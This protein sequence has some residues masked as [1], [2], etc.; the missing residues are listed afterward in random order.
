MSLYES[1]NLPTPHFA[2]EGGNP[3]LW[4]K[5]G[6]R[7]FIINVGIISRLLISLA[8]FFMVGAVCAE[9]STY[10]PLD[11]YAYEA[12]ARLEA[13]GVIESGLTSM[14]PLSRK[15]MARL[16]VEAGKNAEGKSGSVRAMAGYLKERFADEING[17]RFV[18][19]V[20]SLSVRYAYNSSD[21]QALVYNNDGD[22]YREGS[23]EKADF[24]SRAE[25]GWISFY[26]NPEVGYPDNDL[27][28]L[29]A[30]AKAVDSALVCGSDCN[31]IWASGKKAEFSLKSAYGVASFL[32]LDLTLGKD[33][34]W[35]GPGYHG[36]FLLSNNAE[37][38]TMVRIENPE[39]VLLP[40]IFRYLGP[41]RVAFF[42]TQ[43]EDDRN[44]VPEPYYWGMRLDFKPHPRVEIGFQRAALLGGE[45]R[46]SDLSIWWKSFTGKGENLSDEEAGDQKAGVDMKVTLP[47][48]V[49]PVQVYAEVSGEDEAGYLPSRLAYLGGIYLPR[50]LS[51][52][53]LSLRAEYATNHIDGHPNYWYWHHIY[54][55]GYTYDGRIIGH[56]M[57]SDSK[58]FFAELSCRLSDR[59]DY[60]AVAY[61]R[62][63]HNR[64]AQVRAKK[65]EVSLNV[66]YNIM[67]NMRV[68][69]AYAHGK[70][71]NFENVS[72]D[73][74]SVDMASVTVRY[75]F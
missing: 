51:A 42:V 58:D 74:R 67:K 65:D 47:F 27:E 64:S 14:K 25:L 72:G 7:D 3:S 29:G 32:G 20:D 22:Q 59:G 5:E 41:F 4:Q 1:K 40:W 10:L 71:K 34:Q 73:S 37:P 68:S 15:E 8:L 19:P 63:E 53:R 18:K 11:D 21:S 44:D 31:A 48:Q 33:S 66:E 75:S 52:D 60:V 39:P 24:T 26:V 9:A 6:R 43:L 12:V 57:G 45:G 38:F 62:E 50:I 55:S 13:E 69:A 54:Q 49:Q 46:P 23:N 61:D 28:P 36:A 17:R 16:A 30:A 35:W 56:H 2:K 70:I